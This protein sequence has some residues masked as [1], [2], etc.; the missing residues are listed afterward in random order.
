MFYDLAKYLAEIIQPV[1][2]LTETHIKNTSDFVGKIKHCTLTKNEKLV[3]YDVTSLFTSVP[4]QSA[5]HVVIERLEEDKTLKDRTDLTPNEIGGLL[6]QC[7]ETQIL[8]L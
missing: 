3:S 5:V 4:V 2:G 7:L 8:L 6:R 1:V